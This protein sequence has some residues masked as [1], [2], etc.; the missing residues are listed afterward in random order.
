MKVMPLPLTVRATTQVGGATAS[1]RYFYF[2][3]DTKNLELSGW[4]ESADGFAG[5][6]KFWEQ[7]MA[8]WPRSALPE[9]RN[10][11]FTKI[12]KWDAIVY[13]VPEPSA[14][15]K[16]VRAHWV[17]AGTWIDVHVSTTSGSRDSLASFLETLEVSEK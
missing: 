8:A 16:N 12:G 10:V 7:E 2:T 1:P 4:F 11:T 5:V 13:D 15:I 9:P 6:K 17:Q 3:D 14:P